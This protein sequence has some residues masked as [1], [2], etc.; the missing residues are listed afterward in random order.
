[1]LVL[2]D[3]CPYV[4]FDD[5]GERY[6]VLWPAG[7]R[8]DSD[9]NAVIP[10]AGAA[11]PVGLHVHGGAGYLHVEDVERLAGSEASQRAADC[12]DN[13]YGEVAVVNNAATAVSLVPG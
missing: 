11:M 13:Q 9:N 12:V 8:W 5:V 3:E 2:D 6:P 4:F 7:T 10:P 1:V